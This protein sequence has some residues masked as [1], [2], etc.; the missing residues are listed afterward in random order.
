MATPLSPDALLRA[1]KARPIKLV[2]VGS[3]RTHNRNSVGAWGPVHGIAL[4][5]TAG[6]S[7]PASTDPAYNRNILY[8]GY[9]GLPGPLCTVGIGQ[10][11]A[12]YLNSAGRTNHF[13][14]INSAARDLL[15]AGKLPLDRTYYPGVDHVD[16]NRHLYGIEIINRGTPSQVQLAAAAE[17]CAAICLAHGWSGADVMGH[18]EG[19]RRKTNDPPG[20][21]MG[22]FRRR[23]MGLVSAAAK[24]A[25]SPAPKP[26][27][28]KAQEDPVPTPIEFRQAVRCNGSQWAVTGPIVKPGPNPL[29]INANA[30]VSAPA[31]VTVKTRWVSWSGKDWVRYGVTEH[32]GNE[33]STS[34][35]VGQAAPGADLRLD[36]WTDRP[37]EVQVHASCLEWVA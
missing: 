16:G 20:V 19:T 14:K 28:P 32:A 25:P 2:E 27:V 3:W 30:T 33:G 24:P 9:S 10:D 5:Y 26:A 13:G 18:G 7:G 4:H 12:V 17:V 21:N 35:A 6:S 15:I 1:L 36:V 29:I 37:A 23:V 34:W 11:G 22:A 31:G 8:N